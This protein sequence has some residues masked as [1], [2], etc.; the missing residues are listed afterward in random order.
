MNR[1][2]FSLLIL[3][4]SCD[5]AIVP[6]KGVDTTLPDVPG[7][8]SGTLAFPDSLMEFPELEACAESMSGKLQGC[9]SGYPSS[10]Y[11]LELPPGDY[12]LFARRKSDPE[13]RAY[14]TDYIRCG[15]LDTCVSHAKIA[16]TVSDGAEKRDVE[17]GDW[18]DLLKSGSVGM[19]TNMSS[20][21]P[22]SDLDSAAD[23]TAPSLEDTE[24][25]HNI[26]DAE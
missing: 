1:S 16:V 13:P 3:L 23:A 14:F 18:T 4:A 17:L 10:D 11:T 19:D 12:H 7:K 24:V 22:P 8:I 9:V 20:D 5:R 21:K 26:V 2:L 25:N 6:E 15:S